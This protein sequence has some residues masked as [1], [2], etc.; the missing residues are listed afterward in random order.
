MT[1]DREAQRDDGDEASAREREAYAAYQPPRPPAEMIE[2]IMAAVADTRAAQPERPAR[3]PRR[4]WALA[5]A[6]GVIA[7]IIVGVLARRTPEAIEGQRAVDI[8]AIANEVVRLAE[9]ATIT[10]EPGTVIDWTMTRGG[11]RVRI[12]QRAGAARYE[13]ASGGRFEV[14]TPAGRVSVRGTSFRVALRP[15][16]EETTMKPRSKSAAVAGCAAIVTVYGGWLLLSN[17]AGQAAARAGQEATMHAGRAP[18]VRRAPRRAP[19][20]SASARRTSERRTRRLR[21]RQARE[22]L[23]RLI[24]EARARRGATTAASAS[25]G[26]IGSG[27]QQPTGDRPPGE[28]SADYIREVIRDAIPLVKECY[29][30]GLRGAPELAGT[31]KVT[32]TIIGEPEVGG[33]VESVQIPDDSPLAQQPTMRECIEQT[34]LSLEFPQPTGGGKVKVTYPFTFRPRPTPR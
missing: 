7:A 2:R 12:Q 1:S 5:G 29:E 34:M 9:R 18:L 4:W 24:A 3:R 27:E 20:T 15:A 16:N 14:A 21:D 23:L 33:I 28:L 22:A 19:A 32:F 25:A 13:V 26:A 10:L 30:L 6:A 8:D 11:E 31:L 17:D